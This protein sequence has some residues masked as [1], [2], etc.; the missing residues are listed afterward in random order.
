MLKICDIL[1]SSLTW[2]VTCKK[3]CKLNAVQQVKNHEVKLLNK[4]DEG[5][6]HCNLC[7]RCGACCA[8]WKV[9][10]PAIEADTRKTGGVPIELTVPVSETRLAMKGT[11]LRQKRCCALKG[12]IGIGVSCSIYPYRPAACREFKAS[13]EM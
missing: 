12:Q 3:R 5:L 7:K 1:F 11:E 10:F 8:I 6:S 2:H 4:H 13:W 9:C